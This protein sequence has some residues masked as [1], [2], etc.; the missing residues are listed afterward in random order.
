MECGDTHTRMAPNTEN[1][2]EKKKKICWS[3]KGMDKK[4]IM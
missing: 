3:K 4:E 1:K 2:L